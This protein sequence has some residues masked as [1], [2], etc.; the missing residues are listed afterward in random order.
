MLRV[1]VQLGKNVKALIKI[2]KFLLY[3]KVS[4]KYLQFKII[5]SKSF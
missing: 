5:D 3:I 1:K 2:T 4:I